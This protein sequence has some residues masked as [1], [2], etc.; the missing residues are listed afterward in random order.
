MSTFETDCYMAHCTKT[1]IACT[2]MHTGCIR[3]RLFDCV[4]TVIFTEMVR[5]NSQPCQKATGVTLL[6]LKSKRERSSC[7]RTASWT[8]SRSMLD[9]SP[10]TRRIFLFS[11]ILFALMVV[12]SISRQSF[13]LD[14]IIQL[15]QP[16]PRR[17]SSL[18]SPLL[19]Q[20]HR[21]PFHVVFLYSHHMPIPLNLLSWTF[22]ALRFFPA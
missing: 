11:F 7:S 13:L 20:L 22:F 18:L 21:P 17:H 2:C 8:R 14:I 10:Q 4:P 5:H 9:N 16:S 1:H 12:H 19:F 3:R 6:I 15:V